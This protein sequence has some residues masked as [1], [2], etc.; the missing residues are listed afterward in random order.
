M[1]ALAILFEY[2]GGTNE[3]A[4]LNPN[5]S[6]PA[7]RMARPVPQAVHLGGISAATLDGWVRTI[8]ERPLFSPSRRPGQVVVATTEVPRLAGIIIGPGGARAIFATG[9]DARAIVAGVGAHAG[10]YLIRAV[11]PAGVSVVGPNG[12][13]LLHPAFDRNA[14]RSGAVPG[15][16]APGGPGSSILDL[17]RARVQNGEGMRPA[18][19]P[20]QRFQAPQK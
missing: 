8:L 7:V 1:L 19:S 6:V 2:R 11:A 18:P 12:P 5:S 9:G 16:G 13:E 10:P 15:G 3:G 14:A 20:P 17:L 4:V